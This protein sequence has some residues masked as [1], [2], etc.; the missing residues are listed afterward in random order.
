MLWSGK[1]GTYPKN[2]ATWHNVVSTTSRRHLRS[3]RELQLFITTRPEMARLSLASVALRFLEFKS[4]S[5]RKPWQPQTMFRELLNMEGALAT[6][7]KY[8]TNFDRAIRLNLSVEWQASKTAWA[9]Q[10]LQVQPT[11]LPAA[12]KKDILAILASTTDPHIRVFV[13]FLWLMAG[14]KGD[15]A[16]LR[17]SSIDLQRDRLVFFVQEGKAVFARQ[18]KYR[19]ATTCPQPWRQEI[20]DFLALPRTGKELYL[21]RRELAENSEV[22]DA[23]RKANSTL[24]VRSLRRGAAQALARD[25]K[26]T[27]EVLMQLTGHKQKATLYR[28]LDWGRICAQE[29]LALATATAR[30]LDPTLP[31]PQPRETAPTQHAPP[32]QP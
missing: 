11:G 18:G 6:V 16:R 2:S 24:D 13:M 4:T 1:K 26:V 19:V 5:A 14:R 30:N 27:P 21:F 15:V 12:S 32:Q 8:S 17:V 22:L 3:L 31:R 9:R 20:T 29:H 28:Y 10:S 7:G 25:D 23:I